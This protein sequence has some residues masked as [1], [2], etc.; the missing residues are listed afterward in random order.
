[1]RCRCRLPPVRTKRWRLLQV[2]NAEAG[3]A[4]SGPCRMLQGSIR[5]VVKAI[6]WKSGNVGRS[7]SHL[8]TGETLVTH[9]Y[10]KTCPLFVSRP[11]FSK[12]FVHSWSQETRK[13]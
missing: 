4:R 10:L 13:R 7:G 11:K 3:E 2:P 9:Q 1:M 12:K 6:G 5:Q 8:A